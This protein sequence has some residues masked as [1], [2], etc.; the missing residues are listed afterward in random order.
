M[1][2]RSETAGLTVIGFHEDQL[3]YN[4]ELFLGY[5]ELGDVLFVNARNIKEI[6]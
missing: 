6:N 3:K 5:H 4:R 2:S 1:V